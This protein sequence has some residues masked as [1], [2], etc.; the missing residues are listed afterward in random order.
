MAAIVE[1]AR[2]LIGTPYVFGHSSPGVGC[3]CIGVIEHVWWKVRGTRPP[4][5]GAV[6]PDYYNDQSDPLFSGAA[7]CLRQIDSARAGAV[8][9]FKMFETPGCSHIGICTELRKGRP[10]KMVH[11]HDG[12]MVR[13]VIETT[14]GQR[15]LPSLKGMFEI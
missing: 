9:V 8:L 13:R 14:L 12:R 6:V 7:V 10:Y 11:A 5:R 15:W 4:S 2:G 3:D 1:V